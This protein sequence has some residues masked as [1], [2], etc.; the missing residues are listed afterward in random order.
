MHDEMR[1]ACSLGNVGGAFLDGS[2]HQHLEKISNMKIKVLNW[3][4]NVGQRRALEVWVSV[5]KSEVLL[6]RQLG[7]TIRVAWKI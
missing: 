7:S 3:S 4:E 2:Q 1:D 6:D 5:R